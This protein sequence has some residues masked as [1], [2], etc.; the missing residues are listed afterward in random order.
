MPATKVVALNNNIP[1][2]QPERLSKSPEIVEAACALK[3]D[4][5]VMVA[6]GQILKKPVLEMAPHGVLNLHGSLLPQYRGPAPINWAIINGEQ[7]TGVTTMFS[8]AGVD[9]GAMFLKKAVSI[10]PDINAGELAKTLAIL[11]SDLVIETLDQILHGIIEPQAQDHSKASYA[12]MLTKEL[13]AINW[14]Q[15]AY[16]IHNQVRGLYPWP[17]TYTNFSDNQ[18]KIITTHVCDTEAASGAQP[19]QIVSCGEKVLV[20]CG[21]GAQ[22]VELEEVQPANKARMKGRDWAN[23]ARL[24]AGAILGSEVKL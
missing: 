22:T 19:G 7:E 23:G 18:L 10:D 14:S 11:G 1:V 24:K 3:P 21:S 16:Q 20:A 13:G 6:F 17:G 4:I 5:L 12:P 15:S 9:T 8:D 2:M